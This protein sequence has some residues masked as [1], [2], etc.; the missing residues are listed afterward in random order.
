MKKAK[1]QCCKCNFIWEALPNNITTKKSGCPVCNRNQKKDSSLEV[2]WLVELSKL[3]RWK[4]QHS[5]NIGQH[6]VENW[7][8]DGYNKRNQVIFEFNGDIWHGNPKKFKSDAKSH[9]YNKTITAGELHTKTRKRLK[10]LV[11]LGYTVVSIWESDYLTNKSPIIY[12][13]ALN[14]AVEKLMTTLNCSLRKRI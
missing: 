3:L 9:P 4:I 12:S 11:N 10:E 1:H 13:K 8:L 6:R 2:Q 5:G 7:Y 14:K